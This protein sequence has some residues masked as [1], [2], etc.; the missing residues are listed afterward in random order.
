MNKE[1]IENTIGKMLWELELVLKSLK[2][3]SKSTKELWK[4][5]RNQDDL[6]KHFS[7]EKRISEINPVIQSLINALNWANRIGEGE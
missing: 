1:Y 2:H 4:Q 3:E 5:T 6:E 7:I